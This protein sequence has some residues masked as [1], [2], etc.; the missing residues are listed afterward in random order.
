MRGRTIALVAALGV[1]GGLGALGCR[2]TAEEAEDDKPAPAAVTCRPVEAA[3]IADTIDVAGVIAPP[4]KLDAVVGGRSRRGRRA[5]R[6]DRGSGAAGR[7]SRGQ[8]RGR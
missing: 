3:T 8:G 4:P 7:L 1:L 5:A 6:G 2:R